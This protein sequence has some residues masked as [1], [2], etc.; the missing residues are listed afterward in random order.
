MIASRALGAA[1]SV[2]LV[3]AAEGAQGA[4]PRVAVV[5]GTAPLVH[6]LDVALAPWGVEVTEHAVVG[7]GATMPMAADRARALAHDA[8]TDVVVWLSVAGGTYA[9]W[10]YDADSD[11]ASTR[12]LPSGPPFDET[13]AAG[14]A[15]SVK[16]I[17]RST[18]V[19]PPPERF[20][21]TAATRGGAAWRVDLDVGGAAR[22]GEPGIVE[23][24]AGV[25]ASFW[26]GREEHLFGVVLGLEGG[27]GI[28]VEDPRFTATVL[29]A[30]LRLAIAARWRIVPAFALEGSVGGAA[31]ALFIDGFVA[32]DGTTASL[33][34][35]DPAF[36]PR[37]GFDFLAF[38]GRLHVGPWIGLSY[39]TRSQSI[40]IHGAQ[41]FDL[42]PLTGQAALRASLEFQ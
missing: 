37:L 42:A 32:G 33:R 2:S 40:T 36:E 13:T 6:A 24:R 11:H 25:A 39:L 8:R 21:A 22:T 3:L 41:V 20:G 35:V 30:S 38:E 15:L 28:R 14:I 27:T 9:L 4:S 23:P 1:L 10:V 5:D 17:L 31:H 16:T 12:R 29:D 7:P 26:P 34:R 18:T 19:A